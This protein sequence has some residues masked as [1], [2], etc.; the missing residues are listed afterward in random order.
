MFSTIISSLNIYLLFSSCF[1]FKHIPFFSIHNKS[2]NIFKSELIR[3]DPFLNDIDSFH[4]DID[5]FVDIDSFHADI[6]TLVSFYECFN[7]F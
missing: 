7:T 2:H 3:I 5:I 6:D 4:T 1:F